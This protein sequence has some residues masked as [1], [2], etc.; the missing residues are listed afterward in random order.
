MP[1]ILCTSGKYTVITY[2]HTYIHLLYIISIFMLYKFEGIGHL[3]LLISINVFYGCSE[4]S[5]ASLNSSV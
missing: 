4:I 5:T 1:N 3:S 2:I